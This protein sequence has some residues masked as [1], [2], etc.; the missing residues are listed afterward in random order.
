MAGHPL[1]RGNPLAFLLTGG[2]RNDITQARQ[3]SCGQH[4]GN[5]VADKGYDANWFLELIEQ[6]GATAVIPSRRNRR[7]QPEYDRHL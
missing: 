4:L 1:G 2:N 5:V 3:L 6:Q 7:Q